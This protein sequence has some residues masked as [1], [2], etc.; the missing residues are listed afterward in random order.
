MSG[1]EQQQNQEQQQPSQ[2][3]LFMPQMAAFASMFPGGVGMPTFGNFMAGG[4]QRPH[5]D[6][7]DEMISTIES[8]MYR[9]NSKMT[10]AD[11]DGELVRQH[12]RNDLD[13]TGYIFRTYCP[14]DAWH[15]LC[16]IHFAP[17]VFMPH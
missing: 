5:G 17:A 14:N 3:P 1:Q 4:V 16:R 6:N 15:V 8:N 7:T 11:V 9:D 13:G 10:E 2:P 12:A